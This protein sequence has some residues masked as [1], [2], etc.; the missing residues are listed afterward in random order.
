ME[1]L[2]DDDGALRTGSALEAH[3]HDRCRRRGADPA[4]DHVTRGD[5]RLLKPIAT[6]A[7]PTST[8]VRLSGA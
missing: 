8:R 6:G 7:G 3:Q 1:R 2:C 4:G 5:A